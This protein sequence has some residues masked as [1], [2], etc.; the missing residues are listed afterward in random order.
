M[1]HVVINDF[2]TH[3]RMDLFFTREDFESVDNH[4]YDEDV[5]LKEL[6][7]NYLFHNRVK[8]AD[9]EPFHFRFLVANIL[10]K[11]AGLSDSDKS[12]PHHPATKS[13][14]FAVIGLIK[15]LA[16]KSDCNI[17]ILKLNRIGDYDLY[18][19]FQSIMRMTIPDQKQLPKSGVAIIVD[20]S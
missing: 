9:L 15:T 17:E 3:D 16:E 8:W 11:V 10:Q 14:H 7:N 4:W 2:L 20:N 6:Q 18:V 13:L 12:D 19:E 1:T 5:L